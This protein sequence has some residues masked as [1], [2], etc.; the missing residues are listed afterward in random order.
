MDTESS[1]KQKALPESF[2]QLILDIKKKFK[3]TSVL[4]FGSRAKKSA[5][6][7]SDYDLIFLF[8]K[9]KKSRLSVE[10]DIYQYI[11]G[12][13]FS[14]DILVYSQAQY[15]ELKNEFGSL[16]YEANQAHLEL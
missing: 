5:N 1:S 4:L 13:G 15:D 12:C 11:S 9:L 8:Q 3:P 10:Q 6:N 2:N 14:L 16:P 7:N